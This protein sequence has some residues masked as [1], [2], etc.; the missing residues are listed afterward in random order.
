M[1]AWAD[2]LSMNDDYFGPLE[3]EYA[4]TNELM[5]IGSQR[6]SGI[7]FWKKGNRLAV[8]VYAT[9]ADGSG[10]QWLENT[11]MNGNHFGPLED[12]YADT[13]ELLVPDGKIMI[14]FSLYKKGNKVAP[15]ICVSNPDGSG[16]EWIENRDMND[17]YFGPLEEEYGDTNSIILSPGNKVF[18]FRLW[19][20]DNRVAPA[21]LV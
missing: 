13:N 14:G 16:R 7:Q 17:N 19:K 9:N 11:D 18:G 1:S 2:V 5:C 15:R 8:K 10:G 4:D 20:K 12:Q 3:E 21:L 6:I